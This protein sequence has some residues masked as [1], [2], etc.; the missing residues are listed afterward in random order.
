MLVCLGLKNN[1][2]FSDG[3]YLRKFS[4]I[5]GNTNALLELNGTV[6]SPQWPRTHT[7]LFYNLFIPLCCT[8]LTLQIYFKKVLPFILSG[9][10]NL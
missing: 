6:L 7:T 3:L 5:C 8:F 1:S 9:Y 4:D 10:N 2:F